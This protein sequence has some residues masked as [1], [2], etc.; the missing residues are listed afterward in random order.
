MTLAQKRLY[1]LDVLNTA[2][3]E[4]K[5]KTGNERL[6]TDGAIKIV[7]ISFRLSNIQRPIDSDELSTIIQKLAENNFVFF[8]KSNILDGTYTITYDGIEELEK[9]KKQF[10]TRADM[11]R[12]AMRIQDEIAQQISDSMGEPELPSASKNAGKIFISHSAKDEDISEAFQQQVLQLALHVPATDIFNVSV[13]ESGIKGGQDFKSRIHTELKYA[14]AVIMLITENYKGSQVCLN[15]M[16]A[17]WML[18]EKI[19]VIPF[20]LPPITHKTV[21]FIHDT[22]QQFQLDSEDD[23]IKF[24][25]ENKG[26][27]KLFDAHYND[28]TLKKAVKHFLKV[29]E[30]YKN[31][32]KRT[33]KENKLAKKLLKDIESENAPPI[34]VGPSIEEIVRQ[35]KQANPRVLQ[36]LKENGASSAY[37][38]IFEEEFKER[39]RKIITAY[40]PFLAVTKKKFFH[41]NRHGG[42]G[43]Y[44]GE[45]YSLKEIPN[46]LTLNTLGFISQGS[47]YEEIEISDE[48]IVTLIGEPTDDAKKSI[49][50]KSDDG[51][52]WLLYKNQRRE[53]KDPI[54]LKELANNPTEA[55]TDNRLQKVVKGDVLTLK[56]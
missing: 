1:I 56:G 30:D 20:I 46:Y 34:N 35:S 38:R 6:N 47:T 19:P 39:R 8:K 55:V 14:K 36:T 25:S 13:P 41:V 7:D 37:I 26:A 32:D 18:V 31:A 45:D 29:V 24:V 40:Y 49:V 12:E 51:R 52:T 27:D 23:L 54:L 15:E 33:E 44:F 10:Y 43:Y 4:F 2:Y 9:L 48:H 22:T 21:G 5:N 3:N 42:L 11:E 16:G 28:A 53:V 17:A 50:W